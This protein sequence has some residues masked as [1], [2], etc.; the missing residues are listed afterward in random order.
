MRLEELN[1]LAFGP[2]T[3][4][5]LDFRGAGL[6]LIYGRNEAGKS[7][8]LRAIDSLLFGFHAKTNDNFLHPYDKLRVGATLVNRKGELVSFARRKKR[9]PF[10]SLDP[11]EKVLPDS[12]L[13]P[14]LH[15]IEQKRFREIY[16]IDHPRLREGG[17]L[18]RRLQGLA[19]ES[20]LVAS[21]SSELPQLQSDIEQ[22]LAEIYQA[23]GRKNAIKLGISAYQEAKRDKKDREVRVSTWTKLQ[24]DLAEQEQK[25]AALNAHTERIRADLNRLARLRDALPKIAEWKRVN[26][27]LADRDVQ[28]LPPTYSP[29]QR[30]TCELELQSITARIQELE[31]ESK[32]FQASL[33]NITEAPQLLAEAE[34]IEALHQRIGEQAKAQEEQRR[35]VFA[36]DADRLELERLRDE[37]NPQLD[38]HQVDTLRLKKEHRSVL[39]ELAE[40]ERGIRESPRQLASQLDAAVRERERLLSQLAEL[41]PHVDVQPLAASLRDVARFE[42]LEDELQQAQQEH[43]ALLERSQRH[44]HSLPFWSGTLEELVRSPCPLRETV[45]QHAADLTHMQA[46]QQ[47]LERQLED[48]A[49]KRDR[50]VQELEVA[51]KT[52]SIVTEDDLLTSREARDRTWDE[53]QQ[54]LDSV[55]SG[56]PAVTRPAAVDVILQQFSHQLAA[57]DDIADRLRREADRVAELAQRKVQ[58]AAHTQQYDQLKSDM[59]SLQGRETEL[60]SKWQRIWGDVGVPAPGTPSEMNAWLGQR[61]KLMDGALKLS[62]QTKRITQLQQN[63]NSAKR[64]LRQELEPRVDDELDAQASLGSLIQRA[65][66]L[67]DDARETH[68][69]RAQLSNDRDRLALT[70][71]STKRE[72]TAAHEQLAAW[73]QE[74][75]QAMQ[76]IGCDPSTSPKLARARVTVLDELSQRYDTWWQRKRRIEEIEKEAEAFAA[77][78]LAIASRAGLDVSEGASLDLARKLKRQ[79]D[80]AKQSQQNADTLRES[81]ATNENKLTE[82][83]KKCSQLSVQLDHFLNLAG[84]VSRDELSAV[85]SLSDRACLRL[86]LQ[87]EILQISG[88][89][90]FATFVAE[91]VHA[92]VDKLNAKLQQLEDEVADLVQRRDQVTARIAEITSQQEAI[93]GN[94]SAAEADQRAMSCLAHVH[95]LS[96]RY[97][98]L[99]IAQHLLRQHVERYHEENQDPLLAQASDH[100]AVMTDHEFLGLQVDYDERDRPVLH[101]LRQN[102]QLVDVLAMSDGTRDPMFLALR[103]A[104]L[105]KRLTK[106]EPMPF[107]VD[108]ILIHL[109][110]QRALAT[111]RVLADLAEQTQVLFFTHHD[112]LRELAEQHL[113]EQQLTVH[114]LQRTTATATAS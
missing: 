104:Y 36:L 71:E 69:L 72:L 42:K 13:E 49:R 31:V 18:L 105:Q 12:L 4:Q 95:T 68:T 63:V 111:L 30:Q 108:D 67:L 41:G 54:L 83:R 16:S 112:R 100:F 65:H 10:V 70:I 64:L 82:L 48:T 26:E 84:I 29:Q 86:K 107:I 79:L 5:A 53:I 88:G 75:D 87:E 91:S 96:R 114:E 50:L 1:L 103:L 22:E 28:I 113:S 21:A 80:H 77:D 19:E 37:V 35:A 39:H 93:D 11:G 44:L 47:T 92:D 2:F 52:R 99:R 24:S 101:G 43:E 56:D 73:Q 59:S 57:A 6:Q 102:H 76:W 45:D 23:R 85:E 8:A 90:D 110:D 62:Q 7:S 25:K 94:A 17:E 46:Q 34:A 58:I 51:E 89:T 38:L 106:H 78:A 97:A 81:L 33:D 98:L 14:F 74:W 55:S 109:D 40:S 15:G 20:L 27:E 60:R 9:R 66:S 3:G 32:D 61:D